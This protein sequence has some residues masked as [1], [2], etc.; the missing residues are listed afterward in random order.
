MPPGARDAAPVTLGLALRQ[1][2]TAQGLTLK[3]VA[4]AAGVSW[5]YLSDLERGTKLPSLETLLDLASA[6]DV[7]V[8]D[9]LHGLYPF[10]SRRPPRT[11][12][13]PPDGRRRESR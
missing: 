11:V 5:S 1:R 6:L 7:L 3:D 13:P 9:L 8:T 10:G 12:A 4:E 2:R